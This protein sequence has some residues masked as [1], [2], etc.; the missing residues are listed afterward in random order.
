MGIMSHIPE[1]FDANALKRNTL[2]SIMSSEE[3]NKYFKRR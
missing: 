2:M 3:F 1:Q